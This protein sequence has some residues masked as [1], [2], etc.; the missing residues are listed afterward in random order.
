MRLSRICYRITFFNYFPKQNQRTDERTTTFLV[1]TDGKRASRNNS[2]WKVQ[3]RCREKK[4]PIL[5][6]F[7]GGFFFCAVV[8]SVEVF[9]N[10]KRFTVTQFKMPAIKLRTVLRAT[11]P[12]AM[13]ALGFYLLISKIDFYTKLLI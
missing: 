1:P 9:L 8:S 3:Q 11:L 5:E 7:L 12:I 4:N 10:Y 2:S 6:V 13:S